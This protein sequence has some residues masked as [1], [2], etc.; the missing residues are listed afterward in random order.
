MNIQSS[1]LPVPAD[2]CETSFEA[3]CKQLGRQELEV[4]LVC[5][6]ACEEVAK[7]IQDKYHCSLLIVPDELMK[8]QY[9]WGVTVSTSWVFSDIPA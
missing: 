7:H 1:K 2:L 5:P 8:S 9:V 4:L 3:A 6:V